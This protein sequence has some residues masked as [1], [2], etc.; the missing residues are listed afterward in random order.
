MRS[1][2]D[3]AEDVLVKID[4]CSMLNSLE[5]RSPFL[6]KNVIDFAFEKVP[7]MLK[8]ASND[9]KI[10]LK[11][12]ARRVLPRE[13]DY[14]RKQGFS[15]PLASWMKKG[16]WRDVV[17]DTLLSQHCFF[18]K[19]IIRDMLNGL[20]SKRGNSERLFCLVLF[21]LWRRNYNVN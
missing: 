2:V 8:V 21:E 5:V 12:L 4:R 3:K 10:L 20:D 19:E 1:S 16:P 15:T 18:D 17:H 13:F 7:S 6:D 11:R 9:R 14:D